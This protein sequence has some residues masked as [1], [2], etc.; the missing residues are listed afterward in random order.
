MII[1]QGVTLICDNSAAV[2][3]S[4]HDLMHRT[5]SNFDLVATITYL[6]K[7]W[8]RD[9][10]IIYSWVKG[11]ADQLD[12]PLTRNERL[13][14]EADSIADHIQMEA[15][16]P[17]GA[18]PQCNHWELERV[19]LSIEEVKCTGHM[20]QQLRS[21]LLLGDMRDY[22]ML[23]KEWT[24]FTLESVAWDAYG[25][26]FQPLSNNR[27]VAVSKVNNTIMK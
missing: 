1:I 10:I 17:R 8:C 22:L 15:R 2:L 14:I 4:K 13:N 11:R 21:Q 27:R 5:E 7:E 16:G 20:K 6:E 24:P 26:T 9:I 3:A 25:T 18:R 12:R 19:S 23:K